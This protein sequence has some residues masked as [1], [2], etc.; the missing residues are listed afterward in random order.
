MIITDDT[1]RENLIIAGKHLRMVLDALR[2]AVV[3]GINTGQ[4]EN[5]AQ[6]KITQLG[7]TPAFLNY[8]PQGMPRPFPATTC[9]SINHEIVHGVPN[10]QPQTIK[11][12][13]IVSIDCGL[14]H[15]GIFVDAAFTM[16][17][18]TINEQA[19]QLIEATRKA[20]L[21]ATVLVQAG[22]TTGDIGS[23][24]E[25]VAREYSFVV[26]PEL[27]GHGVGNAQH[28]APFIPNIG[29]A[30]EG[31]TLRVGEVIAIEPILMEGDDPRIKLA[32]DGFTYT[33]TDPNHRAAHFEH[34]L[35]VTNGAPVVVT[36]PAW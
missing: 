27:G 4:L 34:T 31:A 21:Y 9:V 23:A 26:P 20:I 1:Q 36:G 15:K 11:I 19:K 5:V 10:E 16:P 3:P 17:V 2:E 18:G 24:V 13:D 32:S 28:E 29:N 25:E 8:Q 22:N 12:G 6:E 7:D 33:T 35:L 14:S 30:G